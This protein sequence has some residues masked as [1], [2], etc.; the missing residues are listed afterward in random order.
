MS[1]AAKKKG[2]W[3]QGRVDDAVDDTP[4]TTPPGYKLQQ[5]IPQDA[6]Y[7]QLLVCRSCG[8]VV[9]PRPANINDH[10]QFHDLLALLVDNRLRMRYSPTNPKPDPT[11]Q[12]S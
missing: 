12:P 7:G 4:E 2:F 1:S 10:T 11:P 3:Q 9:G 8:A 5:G 6:L